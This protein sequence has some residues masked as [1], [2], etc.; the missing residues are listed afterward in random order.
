VFQW[1]VSEY[2]DAGLA[3]DRRWWTLLL[4][5][6]PCQVLCLLVRTGW[7]LPYCPLFVRGLQV[8]GMFEARGGVKI[9]VASG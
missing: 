7:P 9:F 3:V 8:E 4:I 2:V 1:G 5:D 6:D